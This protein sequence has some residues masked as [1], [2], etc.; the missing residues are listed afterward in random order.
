MKKLMKNNFDKSVTSFSPEGR[1]YQIEYS[2][3]A[4]DIS[5]ATCIATKG[6]NTVCL[7][8]ERKN[9]I[10]YNIPSSDSISLELNKYTGFVCSG[11]PGDLNYLVSEIIQEF[12]Y[13]NEKNG[14]EISI[15][16]LA[17]LIANKNQVLSQQSITRLLGVKTIFFGIDKEIG[18]IIIKMDPSGYFSSH[19]ICAIGE[20]SNDFIT[21]IQKNDI[22][23]DFRYFKYEKLITYT[24]SLLQNILKNDIKATDIKITII[25]IEKKFQTLSLEDVDKYLEKLK[26]INKIIKT[27]IYNELII[28]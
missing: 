15:D 21:Y 9:F 23:Y 24:I 13:F 20:N 19:S 2:I 5:G 14:H 22:S 28:K 27:Q 8:E 25:S 1:V 12:C 4:A 10:I 17:N 7:I 18:P 11:I 26:K 16:Q 3:R 6:L